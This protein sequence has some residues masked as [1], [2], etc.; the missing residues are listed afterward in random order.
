[1]KY[2][3]ALI[4]IVPLLAGA[5]ENLIIKG[6]PLKGK[7]LN[8]T[9]TIEKSVVP[10]NKKGKKGIHQVYNLVGKAEVLELTSEIS[11]LSYVIELVEFKEVNGTDSISEMDR[12]NKRNPSLIVTNFYSKGG[13]VELENEADFFKKLTYNLTPETRMAV[14]EMFG[15]KF[16]SELAEVLIP[17]SAGSYNVENGDLDQVKAEEKKSNSLSEKSNVK[18][19]PKKGNNK[20]EVYL[21]KTAVIRGTLRNDSDETEVNATETS[22]HLINT[23]YGSVVLY[24][25][26]YNGI[27]TVSDFETKKSQEFTIT[28]EKELSVT[29]TEKKDKN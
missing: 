19:L 4:L 6:D 16:F 3:L 10:A 17:Y 5:Q 24:S 1:M 25:A 15:D 18:F 7:V 29:L 12:W 9:E 2:L 13:H 27:H 28:Q 22:T 11:R 14:N 20:D 8:F 26:F 21:Q 23:L